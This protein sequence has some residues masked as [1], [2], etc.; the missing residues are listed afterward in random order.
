MTTPLPVIADVFRCSLRWDGGA[1]GY[2]PINVIHIQAQATGQVNADAYAA[3]N[4]AVAGAMWGSVAGVGI[5]GHVDVIKLDGTSPT[6]SF[7]TGGPA[8]W[9]G[10][11][12]GT[13]VPQVSALVKLQ[14]LVRGRRHRG[15]IY[16]PVTAESA[17]VAGS[18]TSSVVTSMQAAW[19]NFIAALGVIT[20]VA[21]KLGVASYGRPSPSSP[22]GFTPGFTPVSNI[23]VESVTATQRRRT[24]R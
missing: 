21:Y 7:A 10:G 3:L 5:V 1:I 19:T 8:K 6:S 15:R 14:T 11:S 16:L 13:F 20:P 23:T 22:G 18:L 9:Q 2:I 17:V 4:T 24:G 12:T